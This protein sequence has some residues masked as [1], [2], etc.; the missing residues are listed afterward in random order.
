MAK[1][2]SI[3]NEIKKCLNVQP[4]EAY[5]VKAYDTLSYR[6]VI[7]NESFNKKLPDTC[8]SSDDRK[9]L[10]KVKKHFNADFVWWYPDGMVSSGRPYKRLY[11][12]QPTLEI[13]F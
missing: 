5:V 1:I 13:L 2:D 8:C 9:I 10:E 3:G 11:K 6:V 7:N 4:D 12:G